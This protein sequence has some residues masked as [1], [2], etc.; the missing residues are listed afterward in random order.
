M[1]EYLGLC[2]GKNGLADALCRAPDP[3]TA[4][5]AC[6]DY[7]GAPCIYVAAT[8]LP[9]WWVT[10]R[11]RTIEIA[12][13]DGDTARRIVGDALRT[14]ALPYEVDTVELRPAT[15]DQPPATDEETEEF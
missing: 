14:L 11:G 12:V 4:A 13:S 9:I 7:L 15:A 5:T 10:Y 6:A 2:A 1:P 8:T 3:E